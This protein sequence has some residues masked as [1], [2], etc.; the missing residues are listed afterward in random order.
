MSRYL[1]VQEPT[2]TWAV[3]DTSVD[4][5]ATVN[6]K[7]AIGLSLSEAIFVAANANAGRGGQAKSPPVGPLRR[8]SVTVQIFRKRQ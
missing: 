7:V 1:I 3:F 4:I 5:P 2:D 6:G 8:N